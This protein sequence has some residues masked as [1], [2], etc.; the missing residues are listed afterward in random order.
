[1]KECNIIW[2]KDNLN[3][4]SMTQLVQ[5]SLCVCALPIELRRDSITFSHWLGADTEWF[6]LI[7]SW[8][9]HWDGRKLSLIRFGSVI[10]LVLSVGN[11]LLAPILTRV[12][13][14]PYDVIMPAMSWISKTLISS[15]L[16]DLL[17]WLGYE[18][19]SWVGLEPLPQSMLAHC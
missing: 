12:S 4:V 1:M 2:C 18:I 16:Y 11:Q 14:P 15:C 9:M 6:L 7:A 17:H 5:W 3:F 19:V 10:G 13:M 8:Y